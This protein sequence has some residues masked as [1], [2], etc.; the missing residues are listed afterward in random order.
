VWRQAVSQCMSTLAAYQ[1]LQETATLCKGQKLV[2]LGGAACIGA[3]AIQLAKAYTPITLHI[4]THL[5]T[6]IY[7]HTHLYIINM[8][9]GYE[10]KFL[11]FS[12]TCINMPYHMHL[13]MCVYTFQYIYI[14]IYIC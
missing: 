9:S 14:Y 12:H 7:K 4:S 11:H 3:A 6:H 5:S 8:T 1:A 13:V 10:T 2:V